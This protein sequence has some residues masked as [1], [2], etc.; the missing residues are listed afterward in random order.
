MEALYNEDKIICDVARIISSLRMNME[1][2]KNSNVVPT[3]FEILCAKDILA[4]LNEA[5]KV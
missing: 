4:Y 3:S 1:H 5:K 2:P